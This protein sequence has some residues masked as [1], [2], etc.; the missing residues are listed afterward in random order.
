[1]LTSCSMP[2][3]GVLLC[4]IS[5][6]QPP[7]A[8]EAATLTCHPAGRPQVQWRPRSDLLRG[9]KAAGREKMPGQSHGT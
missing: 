1:M 9:S 2:A 4:L 7:A 5:R 3:F 6:F 8:A